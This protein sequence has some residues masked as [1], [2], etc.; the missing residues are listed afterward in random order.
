MRRA[1]PGSARR[2]RRGRWC[3]GRSRGPCP[4]APPAPP[5]SGRSTRRRPRPRGTTSRA[6]PRGPR[7][8]GVDP[9]SSTVSSASSRRRCA[10]RAL[11]NAYVW[12]SVAIWPP[13][14]RRRY[15]VGRRAAGQFGCPGRRRPLQSPS[16]RI[17]NVVAHQATQ[18]AVRMPP[19]L[20]PSVKH[21]V[22]GAGVHGL[23]TAWHLAQAGEEVL[24]V[25]KTG[26][27]AGASGHRLRRRAQQLLPAGDAGAD[28]R[29]RRD[30]GVRPR[31]VPLPRLG[32][33]AL[34]P[35][36]QEA[37][38]VEVFE[39]QQRIGYPSELHHRRGRRRARTCAAL[40]PD[41]RAPGLTVC[42]HEHA[43]GFAFNR[44]SML[45]L[46]DKARAAGAQIVE[47]VEVT[48]FELRQLRRGHDRAHE[49]GRHRRRAGRRRGRPVDR[50]AVGDA[51]PAG[52]AR[53][54]P[55]RR[56]GRRGPADVDL[57]VPAG[58]RGRRRP[59]DVRRPPTARRRRCSTSTQTSRCATTTAR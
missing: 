56:H 45:G 11:R 18:G 46:A 58:G 48:G 43:G 16:T 20:P 2:S 1:P 32:Y 53:R 5:A 3:R 15:P 49:R 41:W 22:I 19:T 36:A 21:L 47:G 54:A 25:D 57:L 13:G 37:D 39:R 4:P 42:L 24:V 44:E 30:L 14:S 40:Y 38:L 26:V 55:A 23:S 31:G 17:G 27:A 34:G 12:W 29:V 28:G 35:P 33:I 7:G 8:S 9:S 6:R 52:Q 10:A 50:V 59:G 51:R